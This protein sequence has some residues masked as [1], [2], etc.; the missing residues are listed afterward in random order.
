MHRSLFL[1]FAAVAATSVPLVAQTFPVETRD[2][3][4]IELDDVAG[5]LFE[6]RPQSFLPPQ[7]SAQDI[8]PG[9]LEGQA[10]ADEQSVTGAVPIWWT[11]KH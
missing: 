10:A 9:F 5:N 11:G 1:C 2:Q 3:L 4:R 6:A 7:F 8:A